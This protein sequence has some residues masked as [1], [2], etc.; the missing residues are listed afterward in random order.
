MKTLLITFASLFIILTATFTAT[1]QTTD[2]V[3]IITADTLR[4]REYYTKAK[5]FQDSAKFDSAIVYYE[6]ASKIYEQTAIWQEFVRCYNGIGDN[7]LRI[8][9]YDDALEYLS[10]ALETGI[11]ELGNHDREIAKSY[12]SLG[13]LHSELYEHDQA[14]DYYH[15]SLSI[16]LQMEVVGLI[17]DLN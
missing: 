1:A 9:S 3:A 6:K 2:S 7:L 17:Q 14:L 11:D 10:Q 12:N 13:S 16:L 8:G 5:T 4:A 15:K